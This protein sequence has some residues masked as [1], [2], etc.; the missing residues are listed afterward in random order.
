MRTS[1]I[2]EQHTAALVAG[3]FYL[4]TFAV[5]VTV[6]FGIDKRLQRTYHL[7]ACAPPST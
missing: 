6:N 1:T 5:V 7:P 3:L 4:L 2:D